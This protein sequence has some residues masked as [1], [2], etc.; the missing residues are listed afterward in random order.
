MAMQLEC[1]QCG[2]AGSAAYAQITELQAET[3]NTH[4]GGR[5]V[6]TPRLHIFKISQTNKYSKN[7]PRKK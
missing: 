1:D 7:G 3:F 5:K 4:K 2:Y 6:T